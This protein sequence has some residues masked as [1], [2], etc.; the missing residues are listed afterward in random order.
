[1]MLR[2]LAIRAFESAL[3]DHDWRTLLRA[4]ICDER[5]RCD[6]MVLFQGVPHSD[7]AD[8]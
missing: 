1:M 7:C 4:S 3:C 6:L 2:I 5:A 8:G